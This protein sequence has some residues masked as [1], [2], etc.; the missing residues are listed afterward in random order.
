M[1]SLVVT[2]PNYTTLK[3]IQFTMVK[4]IADSNVIK[5]NNSCTPV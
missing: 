3:V 1:G 4:N 5:K 2:S